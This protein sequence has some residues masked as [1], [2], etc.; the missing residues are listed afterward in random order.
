MS[1]IKKTSIK[2][3]KS[4]TPGSRD[5]VGIVFHYLDR[6]RTSSLLSPLKRKKF[7]NSQG[8]LVNYNRQFGNKKLYRLI[9][10]K[11]NF[12]NVSGLVI[13]FEYDPNRN[14]NLALIRYE[15]DTIAFIIDLEGLMLN[16]SVISKS[17]KL[18]SIPKIGDNI[19]L[20]EIP[21]GT[22][23]SNIE[24][25]PGS[26][27]IFLR[28]AGSY[29]LLFQKTE[30]TAKVSFKSGIIKTF[31]LDCKAVIGKV[32]GFENKFRVLGKAGVN[33]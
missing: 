15:N 6:S 21:L 18:A 4:T 11:R 20:K 19:S 28:S 14:S 33:R 8:N 13:K 26:G 5:K 32:S 27:S 17:N 1:F 2:K 22:I 23:I 10:F 9:D 16:D 3:Y 30:T 24:K 31:L 12:L 7:K 25:I 29:G